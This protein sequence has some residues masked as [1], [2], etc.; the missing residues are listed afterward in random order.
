MARVWL[1]RAVWHERIYYILAVR[2]R[3]KLGCVYSPLQ[4][5]ISRK[6]SSTFSWPRG[7]DRELVMFKKI[8]KYFIGNTARTVP[9]R[10]EADV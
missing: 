4:S 10:G 1:V 9:A 7:L 8:K 6:A 3:R 2:S 5:T